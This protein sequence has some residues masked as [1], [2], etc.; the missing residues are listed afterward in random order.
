[1]NYQKMLNEVAKIH[2]TTVDDVEREMKIA[3]EASGLN[4]SPKEFIKI[5]SKTVKKTISRN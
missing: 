3:L 2:N 1:M 5:T 4:I